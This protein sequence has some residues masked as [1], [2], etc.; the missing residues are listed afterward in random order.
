MLLVVVWH[1]HFSY[2]ILSKKK[3]TELFVLC[4]AYVFMKKKSSSNSRSDFSHLWN[5]PM[6]NKYLVKG[7]LCKWQIYCFITITRNIKVYMYCKKNVH[8]LP[9]LLKSPAKCTLS[10]ISLYPD[11]RW[12][13]QAR[14]PLN[15]KGKH[16][17][18]S[19]H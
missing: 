6:L 18:S 17:F 19:D 13:N 15:V 11:L 9:Y 2:N 4:E 7:I 5:S 10:F 12:S 16:K 8:L 14:S 3:N 1:C